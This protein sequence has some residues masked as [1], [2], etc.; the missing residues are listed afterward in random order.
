MDDVPL[1][2]E[3]LANLWVEDRCTPFHI[4]LVAELEPDPFSADDGSTDLA[5]VA[6]ELVSRVHR[7]PALGRRMVR[8]RLGTTRPV[9][10][11]DRADHPERHV[12][13]GTLPVGQDFVAWAGNRI[14]DPI[15]R[16]RPLWRADVVGG[17]PDGRVGLLVVVHH[18]VADGLTGVAMV[19]RLLDARP[20]AT[21]AD[22]APDAA[23]TARPHPAPRT[24]SAPEHAGPVARI[25]A[26]LGDF[27]SST[28]PTSLPRRLGPRRRLLVV[29]EPLEGLHRTGH[30]LGAT[31]NDLLVAAVTAGL[32]ALLAQRG[33]LRPGLVARA[34]VPVG[35]TG[36]GQTAGMLAA[37]LPVGETDA[38]VRLGT[39]VRE[40]TAGKRR[41]R[42][43]GGHVMDVTRLPLPLAQL[44]V[45]GLRRIAGSRIGLF[46]TDVPGPQGP[47]WLAGAR[48]V[49]A[50]PVAPLV[51]G[52]PIGVAALSYDGRLAVAVNASAALTDVDVFAHGL[53]TEF[54]V[55]ARAARTRELSA[56][57]APVR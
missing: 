46:V 35:R 38:L 18:V 32:R 16:S 36:A 10:R 28:S 14:L 40:T 12:R 15:D 56:R 47:L 33:D 55:L 52:V 11:V 21:A 45:R 44:A 25:R 39:I 43:G 53:A 1:R 34:S 17:L 50:V 37:G 29:E 26:A 4:A 20:D 27:G 2:A 24:D 9:W 8:R 42:G 23:P 31:V 6:A 48:L 19:S 54:D 22:D 30:A 7:V 5:R 51:Q 49:R 13:C 3:D 41:I 57:A